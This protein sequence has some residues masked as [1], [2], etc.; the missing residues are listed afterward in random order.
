MFELNSEYVDFSLPIAGPTHSEQMP[1]LPKG[2]QAILT[3]TANQAVLGSILRRG[4]SH[5]YAVL[6]DVT[7]W[8]AD[9]WTNVNPGSIY[10]ALDKL[11][12]QG[13][14]SSVNSGVSVKL[15]PSRKE[16]TV[17]QTGKTEFRALLE[18]ALVSIEI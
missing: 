6:S 15:G 5:G 8:Q 11:E 14:I 13:M 17:M 12:S 3:G 4:I 16:Y 7:S 18:S 2:L 9:A 1:Q 10:H